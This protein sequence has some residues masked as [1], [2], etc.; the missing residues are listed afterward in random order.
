MAGSSPERQSSRRPA[1]RRRFPKRTSRVCWG[2]RSLRSCR[3][4]PRRRRLRKSL[5]MAG[6][7]IWS[8]TLR[9]STPNP[10][11]WRANTMAT[12][13][14]SS[15][16]PSARPTGGRTTTSPNRSS[17]RC[18]SKSTRSRAGWCPA[19]VP[20]ARRRPWDVTYAIASTPP[21]CCVPMPNARCFSITTR[22]VMPACAWLTVRGSRALD[23]P[24]WRRHSCPRSS[25]RWSR[26]R[27]RCR[28]Q[29]CITWLSVW[30]VMSADRAG[31]T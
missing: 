7:R 26:C 16:T 6:K 24:G 19:P 15:P 13:S 8:R 5:S 23:D 11:A 28:W 30:G 12:S 25:M 18:A 1:V 3:P 4:A 14:T 27:T 9:R 17:S 31:P 20:G 22:A 29:P 2:C 21:A 10:N